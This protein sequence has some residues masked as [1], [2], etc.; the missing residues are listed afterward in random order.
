MKR[1]S[2]RTPSES[3]SSSRDP[4]HRWRD[5]WRRRLELGEK[6]SCKKSARPG[7][8]FIAPALEVAKDGFGGVVFLRGGCPGGGDA[9]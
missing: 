3:G 8:V 9:P 1:D 7:G 4:H 2:G 6:G 5:R